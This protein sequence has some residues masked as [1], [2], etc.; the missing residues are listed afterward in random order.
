MKPN[1]LGHP[2]IRVGGKGDG[3]YL[4]PDLLNNINIVFTRGWTNFSTNRNKK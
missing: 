2:L 1:E 4:I 3:G